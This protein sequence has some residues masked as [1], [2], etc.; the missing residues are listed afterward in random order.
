MQTQCP[1]PSREVTF[2]LCWSWLWGWA[3]RVSRGC[4]A[5]DILRT[6][7]LSSSGAIS[8]APAIPGLWGR[9][10]IMTFFFLPKESTLYTVQMANTWACNYSLPGSFR[11]RWPSLNFIFF[12]VSQL[13]CGSESPTT[14]AAVPPLLTTSISCH[15]KQV[16]PLLKT[17][18]FSFAK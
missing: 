18:I 8:A 2:A 5:E 17:S 16:I 10:I 6:C 15:T 14:W 1:P 11:D 9:S 12:Q 7:S 3:H 13:T 4:R